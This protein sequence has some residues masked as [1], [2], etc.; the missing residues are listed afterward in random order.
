M[1]EDDLMYGVPG[2]M[3][4]YN[5]QGGGSG[6]LDP[7]LAGAQQRAEQLAAQRRQQVAA[8][9]TAS[10]TLSQREQYLQ[11]NPDVARFVPPVAGNFEVISA[12]DRA[13]ADA[14]AD[15]P[16]QR[17]S[18]ETISAA[19]RSRAVTPQI[20][21]QQVNN[22]LADE[23]R[24]GLQNGVVT[25]N[26][27]AITPGN[28]Q[29]RISS[30]GDMAAANAQYQ[31]ANEIRR[32]IGGGT[33]PQGLSLQDQINRAIANAP[34][35]AIPQGRRGWGVS[36]RLQDSIRDANADARRNAAAGVLASAENQSAQARA[37]QQSQ[38]DMLQA[39]MD[40]EALLQR[41]QLSNEG[42]L[43]TAQL[44][45]RF[46]PR[47]MLIESYLTA[48][49]ENN[50][51]AANRIMDTA[52]ALD[53]VM[54]EDEAVGYAEGGVVQGAAAMAAPGVGTARQEIDRYREYV[55]AA[56]QS[57]APVVSFDKFTSLGT[58]SPPT[59]MAF[60]EGG[61]VPD[62]SDVSGKMVVD[63]NPAAPTDSIPAVV[64]GAAPAK[65]D[66]GEFVLPKDVVMFFG[67]DRL[68]KMI[69]AARKPTEG[70]A[71]QQ[72]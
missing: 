17:G 42:A 18:F 33:R 35:E 67:T 63:T 45:N 40:N 36:V 13:R 8:P 16:T 46:D 7:Q 2:P 57:G 52:S 12:A 6:P 66:S 43:A 71:A 41:Q 70:A 11:N 48:L 34:Q 49:Q 32:S 55:L 44:R 20:A 1:D 56:R 60:A 19:D 39:A 68:N 58:A 29:G 50:T 31:R 59:A 21:A 27:R 64:D 61:M 9:S 25:A 3:G 51:E 4:S 69:A 38:A 28:T 26:G 22:A 24:R 72:Q 62:P 47:D 30:A 5:A 37:A 10:T 15:A 65:L 23:I 53:R 54:A 14:R